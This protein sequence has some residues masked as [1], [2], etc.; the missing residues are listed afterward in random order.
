M[1]IKSFPTTS[2]KAID[3]VDAPGT[4]EAIVAVFGNVDSVGDRIVKGAFADWL[5]RCETDGYAVPVYSHQWRTVPIGVTQEMKEVDEGLYVKARLFVAE[6]EDHEIARQVYTAMKALDPFGKS[7]LREF[8]FAYDIV[9]MVEKK[10]EDAGWVW[11]LLKLDVIEYGPCLKGANDAT[12]LVG[13]KTDDVAANGRVRPKTSNPHRGTPD[14]TP[15]VGG[16]EGQGRP[17]S[18]LV[19]VMSA[20][21]RF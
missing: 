5:K 21:P 4:F 12:R 16:K 1:E 7:A 15:P 11:E 18:T 3:D 19:D 13:V 20:R 17:S 9:E 8:S 14:P 2:V 6:G 10:E